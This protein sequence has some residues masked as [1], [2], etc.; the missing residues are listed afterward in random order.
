[1]SDQLELSTDKYSSSRRRPKPQCARAALDGHARL[2]E[3]IDDARR[4]PLGDSAKMLAPG[5]KAEDFE[6][7]GRREQIEMVARPSP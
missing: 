7:R 5:L 2:S 4:N 3:R 1:M 6:G